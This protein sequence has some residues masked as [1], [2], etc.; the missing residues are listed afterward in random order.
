VEEARRSPK[1]FDA[2]WFGEWRLSCAAD[3][4]SSTTLRDGELGERSILVLHIDELPG[5]R[6]ILR[7]VDSRSPEPQHCQSVGL[8][9]RE[10]LEQER[11][12]YAE[13]RGVRSNSDRERRDDDK[14]QAGASFE[15]AKR[16]SDVL[17]K[18]SHVAL[19]SGSTVSIQLTAELTS[20][21]MAGTSGRSYRATRLPAMR[22]WPMQLDV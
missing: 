18:I 3:Q 16:V 20:R 7:D 17:Q 4:C 14:G 10:R 19:D 11:V 8:R 21:D 15:R 1:G 5:R 9:I 6:P 2:L 22:T 13:D 12:D